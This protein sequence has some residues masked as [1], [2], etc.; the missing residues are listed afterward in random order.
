MPEYS[1]THPDSVRKTLVD[2]EVTRTISVIT[3]RGRKHAPA[4]SAFLRTIR[5]H[6]WL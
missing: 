3:V 1:V 5:G 4:V 2:P 6:K